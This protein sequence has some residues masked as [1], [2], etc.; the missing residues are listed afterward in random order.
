M[1]LHLVKLCAGA[2]GLEDLVARI[3]YRV[4][5]NADAGR[6]R[7]HDHLTRMHPRREK[8]LLTGGS[9]YWVIKGVILARQ[10]IIG[11]ERRTGSDQIERTAILLDPDYV[12]T[13]PAPRR[14]FQG[15]RYLPGDDAP[16]DL[17]KRRNKNAPPPELTLKL[18]ELGLL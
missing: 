16:S 9:I 8:E 2:D 4:R 12:R 7:V 1:T 10:R 14:A 3:D 6:G 15:W 18:A 13:A 11:F 17:K 5:A